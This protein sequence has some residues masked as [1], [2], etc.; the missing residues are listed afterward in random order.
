MLFATQHL[1]IFLVSQNYCS[2]KLLLGVYYQHSLFQMTAILKFSYQ[3]EHLLLSHSS[4]NLKQANKKSTLKKKRKQKIHK[5]NEMW[6]KLPN[7]KNM[8][9]FICFSFSF[10]SLLIL[11]NKITFEHVYF[12]ICT[13]LVF[14]FYVVCCFSNISKNYFD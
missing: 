8:K 13:I 10:Y 1:G 9:N 7:I 3:T 4:K 12:H 14:F 2:Y 11:Q 5:E 6:N